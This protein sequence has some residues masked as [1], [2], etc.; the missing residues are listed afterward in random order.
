MRYQNQW[1]QEPQEN[2]WQETQRDTQPKEESR[3]IK[4]IRDA[5][6]VLGIMGLLGSAGMLIMANAMGMYSEITTSPDAAEA[7]KAAKYL[8]G[9]AVGLISSSIPFFF[10]KPRKIT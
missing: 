2:Y 9:G 8:A 5:S 1:A 6:P 4:N 3:L 10:V 7:A